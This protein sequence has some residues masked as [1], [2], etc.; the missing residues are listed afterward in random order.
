M[1]SFKTFTTHTSDYTTYNLHYF[2]QGRY[3]REQKTLNALWPLYQKAYPG[4]QSQKI[5]FHLNFEALVPRVQ[6]AIQSKKPRMGKEEKQIMLNIVVRK[7]CFIAATLP[8]PISNTFNSMIFTTMI[9][10]QWTQYVVPVITTTTTL[11]DN[12]DHVTSSR[13]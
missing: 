11:S 10:I 1:Y 2:L 4:Y 7:N 12:C 9:F 6:K 5:I 13:K 8:F 3:H